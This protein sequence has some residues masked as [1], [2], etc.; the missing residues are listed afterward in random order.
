MHKRIV[1]F[2]HMLF[3]STRLKHQEVARGDVCNDLEFV[4]ERNV[5]DVK[6][7]TGRRVS[8]NPEKVYV[9][10]MLLARALRKMEEDHPWLLGVA[11][12]GSVSH[13]SE[14]GYV[15]DDRDRGRDEEDV[16]D[17][18]DGDEGDPIPR[19]VRWRG[20]ADVG[21]GHRLLGAG[22]PLTRVLKPEI[23]ASIRHFFESIKPQGWTLEDVDAV[24]KK[25]GHGCVLR[26]ERGVCNQQDV[27]AESYGRAQCRA[28]YWV[29]VRF[30][31]GPGVPATVHVARA[32]HFVLVPHP[33]L[34]ES[35]DMRFVLLAVY[36]A[37][38]PKGRA[39]RANAEHVDFPMYAVDV[40]AVDCKL[41]SA[42]PEGHKVG[43]MYFMPCVTMTAR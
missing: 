14:G 33:S 40:N 3:V 10:G 9:N 29:K 6:T 5:Q 4:V 15:A 27:S 25:K 21:D 35:L 16:E 18:K 43:I 2:P 19:V 11:H 32:L 36:R 20:A 26:F 12:E 24:L 13:G 31:T 28:N 37:L 30:E 34:E 1:H 41:N 23:S 39:M 8:K 38:P 22:K 17:E 7:V 42:C